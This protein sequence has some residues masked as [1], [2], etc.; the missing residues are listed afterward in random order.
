MAG[1]LINRAIGSQGVPKKFGKLSMKT[2]HDLMGVSELIA[3][4]LGAGEITLSEAQDLF[5]M[6]EQRRKLIETHEHDKRLQN[7]EEVRFD[8]LDRAA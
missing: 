4:K 5:S 6:I 2:T 8:T 3:K 7:L 1:I